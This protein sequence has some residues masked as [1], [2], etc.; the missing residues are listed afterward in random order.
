MVRCSVCE[1]G[2]I[3]NWTFTNYQEI[4]IFKKQPENWKANLKRIRQ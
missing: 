1:A 3:Q 4:D 2:E